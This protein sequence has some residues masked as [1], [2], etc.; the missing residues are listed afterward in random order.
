VAC[1]KVTKEIIDSCIGFIAGYKA[2]KAIRFYGVRC[3]EFPEMLLAGN[4]KESKIMSLINTGHS[5]N[6]TAK[7]LG[8]AKGTVTRYISS[9]NNRVTFYYEFIA[10]YDFINP[11]LNMDLKSILPDSDNSFIRSCMDK[12]VYTVGDFFD[13][14]I[15]Y[16]LK[17]A[18]KRTSAIRSERKRRIF[19]AISNEC[20]SLLA[21]VLIYE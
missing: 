16:P 15:H 1:V 19:N 12:G 7:M 4:E 5:Y 3:A 17:E 6:T 18:E 2:D 9:Y 20:Y 21:E 8:V 13:M 11:V 14:Y 10:F